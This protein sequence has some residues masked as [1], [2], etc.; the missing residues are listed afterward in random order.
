MAAHADR[1]AC[2]GISIVWF[3][4]FLNEKNTRLSPRPY[5]ICL[6]GVEEIH[7]TCTE[8]WATFDNHLRVEVVFVK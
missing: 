3:R 2:R 4:R 8:L 1:S 7:Q 6:A 5:T